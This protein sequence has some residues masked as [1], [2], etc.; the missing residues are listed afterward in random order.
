[1]TRSG[2]SGAY[3]YR[4]PDAAGSLEAYKSIGSFL[5]EMAESGEDISGFIIGTLSGAM[6]LLTP[7]MKGYYADIHYF[8]GLTYEDREKSLNEMIN[9]TPE[10]LLKLAESISRVYEDPGICVIAG[11]NQIDKIDL[12]RVEN[13]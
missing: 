1:M 9:T 13:L 2:L 10:D 4:D 6:P 11:K 3:S 12:D 5:A 7:K 8:S